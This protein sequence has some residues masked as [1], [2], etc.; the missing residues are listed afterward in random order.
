MIGFFMRNPTTWLEGVFPVDAIGSLRL[1]SWF[2]QPG[3]A[4]ARTIDELLDSIGGAHYAKLDFRIDN[5]RGRPVIVAPER[6]GPYMLIEGTHRCCEIVRLAR[7]GEVPVAVLPFVL[8]VCPNIHDY[9][10]YQGGAPVIGAKPWWVPTVD[11]LKGVLLTFSGRSAE[12][13]LVASVGNAWRR[14]LHAFVRHPRDFHTISPRD[15]EQFIAG[16]YEQEG[17]AVTLTPASRDLGRD[18]IAEKAGVG[19]IRVLDQ[20]K[21]YKPGHVVTAEEVRA[22][23]FVAGADRAT[24]C[25]ITTTSTFAPLVPSDRF[26]APHIQSAFLEI[27][28]RDKT[29]AWLQ[30]LEKGTT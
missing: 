10:S 7:R 29:I 25:F 17:Y 13:Q 22:F 2:E 5:M 6:D 30:E 21:R 27:R 4:N 18:I 9:T 1:T 26:I 19:A 28:D 12:G 11:F 15:F 3:Y 8:G 24:K 16:C 23:L 14:I 20:V